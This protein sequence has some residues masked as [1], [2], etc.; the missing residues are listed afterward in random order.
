MHIAMVPLPGK[1]N[2]LVSSTVLLLFFSCSFVEGLSNI[3]NH[4]I[5]NN[6]VVKVS[7]SKQIPLLSPAE[8]K[9]SWLD[10]TWSKGGGIPLL[11][12]ISK[13]NR[14]KRSLIPLFAEETLLHDDKNKNDNYTSSLSYELSDLGPIWKSEIEKHSHLGTVSFLPDID[15][16]GTKLLWNVTFLTKQRQK[17]WQAVTEQSISQACNS[18]AS[19]IADPIKYTQIMK[20]RRPVD[21]VNLPQTFFEFVWKQGGGLPLPLP[22]LPLDSNGYDRLLIPPF[23]REKVLSIGDDSIVYS[24]RNPS[25][26]TFYPV[27]SHIGRVRFVQDEDDDGSVFMV[28]EVAIRPYY[29]CESYVKSFTRGIVQT[30]G[31]NFKA[32]VEL[33]GEEFVIITG[34]K[35]QNYSS[36]L[37]LWPLQVRRDSWIGRVAH[38]NKED[39]RPITW[40]KL[41]DILQPWKWGRLSD[42]KN[43]VECSWSTGDIDL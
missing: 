35:Q 14:C 37:P 41:L 8:V 33:D 27:H 11:I 22:P 3:R 10:Y 42:Q 39:N 23:L 18:L 13:K 43:D 7:I 12:Q 36:S 32:H 5:N 30:V 16:G 15:D 2:F 21:N 34:S 4:Q 20:L 17:L 29:N 25:F 24:V 6:N 31:W 26:F 19:H 9:K 28:W 1:L 38:S 40:D